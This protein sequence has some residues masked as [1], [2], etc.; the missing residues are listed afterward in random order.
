M[1]RGAYLLADEA[2]TKLQIMHTWAAYALEHKSIV[3]V[4]D[5]A[6]LEKMEQWTREIIG[7]I[8]AEGDDRK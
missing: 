6:K 4:F 5:L 2:I 7:E 1:N 3:E 8:R